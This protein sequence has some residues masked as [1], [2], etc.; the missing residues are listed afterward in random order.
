M[1][2]EWVTFDP[3]IR[4]SALEEAKAGD[5]TELAR[6]VRGGLPIDPEHLEFIADFLE[7][8]KPARRRGKQ[9]P[10]S[11]EMRDIRIYQLIDTCRRPAVGMSRTDAVEEIAAMFYLSETRVLDIYKEQQ[12]KIKMLLNQRCKDGGA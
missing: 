8:A 12:S 5:P 7:T 3:G 2:D 4:I 11:Q 9:K 10:F 1:T 6:H